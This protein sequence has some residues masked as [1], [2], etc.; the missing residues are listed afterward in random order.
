MREVKQ[1]LGPPRGVD[2]LLTHSSDVRALCEAALALE[3]ADDWRGALRTT[4][5]AQQTLQQRA[6]PPD[7][8]KPSPAWTQLLLGER[9]LRRAV[10]GVEG[11]DQVGL[12][13]PGGLGARG[14][15][16]KG[17][18]LLGGVFVVWVMDL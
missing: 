8:L 11:S 9:R 6:G 2:Y 4:G 3:R 7:V 1:L 5:S 12:G 16:A 13:G 17:T 15:R 10:Y 18:Y 14:A